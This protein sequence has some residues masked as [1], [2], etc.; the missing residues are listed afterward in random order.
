VILEEVY[1]GLGPV[2]DT[3]LRPDSLIYSDFSE[4]IIVENLRS[5]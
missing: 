5:N 1:N 3:A 4:E 2:Q